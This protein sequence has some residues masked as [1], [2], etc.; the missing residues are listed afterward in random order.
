MFLGMSCIARKHEYTPQS[1]QVK[2]MLK[3]HTTE[4][5]RFWGASIERGGRKEV[6]IARQVSL[7]IGRY[8]QL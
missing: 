6:P 5:A 7:L 8:Q 1:G 3:N 2:G 4:L